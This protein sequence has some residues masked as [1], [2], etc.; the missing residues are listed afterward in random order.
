MPDKIK[1]YTNDFF[2]D[3]G[4]SFKWDK[5]IIDNLKGVNK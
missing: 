1:Q 3:A 4:K 5:S 2:R